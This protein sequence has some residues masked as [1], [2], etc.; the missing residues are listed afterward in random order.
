MQAMSFWVGECNIM[1]IV[2]NTAFV[3]ILIG[4]RTAS[5]NERKGTNQETFFYRI[6][7]LTKSLNIV[8]AKIVINAAVPKS[9]RRAI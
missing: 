8:K 9:A 3:I 4:K 7:D 1:H 2:N 6:I 5:Q